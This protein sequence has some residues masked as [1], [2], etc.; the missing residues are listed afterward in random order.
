MRLMTSLAAG[1]CL[2]L[3]T[4]QM[5]AAQPAYIARAIADAARP[6]KA[7]E[8]DMTRKPAE[9]LAFAEVR[10]GDKVADLMPG[11]GYYTIL[12]SDIVGPGGRVYAIAPAEILKFGPR[13]TEGI[14]ALQSGHKNVSLL[15]PSIND[16]A[17]PE[18][19][20]LV[21][22]SWNYHDLHDPFMGPADHGRLGRDHRQVLAFSHHSRPERAGEGGLSAFECRRDGCL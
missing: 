14:V 9:T 21:W 15:T 12:F 17:A 10:P 18:K 5:A 19:L 16:F 11:A 6:D 7:R 20:D 8:L 1:L 2:G 13:A 3:M 4:V 22:T